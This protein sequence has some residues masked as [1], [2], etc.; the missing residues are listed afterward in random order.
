[1]GDESNIDWEDVTN[2]DNDQVETILARSV[3]TPQ[4]EGK[5]KG[6]ED[7]PTAKRR[8]VSSACIAC[9][10]RKSKVNL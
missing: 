5:G 1:M 9:R 6:K 7:G 4:S 8:C 10:R 2:G 3:Q